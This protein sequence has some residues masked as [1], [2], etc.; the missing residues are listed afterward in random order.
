MVRQIGAALP[1]ARILDAFAEGLY[2]G[3]NCRGLDAAARGLFGKPPSDL[4]AAEVAVLAALPK[5]PDPF[6]KDADRLRERAAFVL[7]QMQEAGL[8]RD[9]QPGDLPGIAED[10][11]C[12]A[13]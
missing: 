5:A 7:L 6:L 1:A 13:P 10:A 9:V 12:A 8:G 3:R 11:G 2:F 4:D